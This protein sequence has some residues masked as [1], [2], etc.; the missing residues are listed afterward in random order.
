MA[1]DRDSAEVGE[2]LAERGCFRS[3]SGARVDPDDTRH[4]DALAAAEEVDG[5]AEAPRRLRRASAGGGGRQ[6]VDGS[7]GRRGSCRASRHPC[8]RRAPSAATGKRDRGGLG[9]RPRQRADP[10]HSQRLSVARRG[11]GAR[12]SWELATAAAARREEL[13]TATSVASA[14]LVTQGDLPDDACSRLVG[15]PARFDRA[16]ARRS[17]AGTSR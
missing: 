16:A 4:R 1:A 5:A 7:A 3:R 17:G 2:R 6:R 10:R 12:R 15:H 13:A 9:E 8:S 11:R 14:G